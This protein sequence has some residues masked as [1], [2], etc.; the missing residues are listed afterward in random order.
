M[1]VKHGSKFLKF[2]ILAASF[3]AGTSLATAQQSAPVPSTPLQTYTASDQ[4]ASVGVPAG[5]NVT[6]AGYAL[7]QMSGPK[8]ESVS[9]GNTLL[10]HNGPYRPGQNPMTIPNQATLT[11]K[12]EAVWQE[13]GRRL[14][15][16]RCARQR[17]LSKTRA[18]RQHCPVR[19][20]PGNLDERARPTK[21]RDAILFFADG[22]QR[23]LQ[24]F[25]YERY[26]SGRSRRSGARHGP[27]PYSP[28]TSRRCLRSRPFSC[29]RRHRCPRWAG[30]L[31][32]GY[33][34][35]SS[36]AYAEQ[37]AQESSDCMDEG[38]IRE[39]P[40]EDLPPYCR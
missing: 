5:W 9:L 10:I 8:G 2:T 7:I 3:I 24:A 39:E 23:R 27:R 29:P 11:Q 6:K 32:A 36:A 37:M 1:Q 26:D 19:H 13:A 31:R 16:S 34:G 33:P 40:E 25:L 30:L 20:L 18:A 14:R 28:V 17:V 21:F 35:G 4:S 22:L 15:F 12:V 38:V